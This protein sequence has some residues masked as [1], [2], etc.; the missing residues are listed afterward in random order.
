MN[1]SIW[2][3][4]KYTTPE[5]K[6]GFGGRGFMI[7]KELVNLGYNVT[8]FAS[9]SNHH[10]KAPSFQSLLF[11]EK[12]GSLNFYWVKTSKY[13][14]KQ[15]FLRIIS[16]FSFEINLLISRKKEIPKPDIIIVSSLSLLSVLTGLF[17]KLFYKSILIFEVRDIWPLTLTE[18]GGYSKKSIFIKILGIIES[19]G[20]KYSDHIVGTMPNLIEHVKNVTGSDLDVSC[21]PMGYSKSDFNRSKNLT[22]HQVFHSIPDNAFVIGYVGSLGVSNALGTFFSLLRQHKNNSKLCFIVAGDGDLS[23]EFKNEFNNYDNVHY[24]GTIPRVEVF[25]VLSNCDLLYLSTHDSEVWKYGQ[26]L[27]KLVDYMLSGVPIVA[28]YSGYKSMI[29]ESNCGV[30]ISP[31]NTSAL[32]KC[33]SSFINMDQSARVQMGLNGRKWIENNRSYDKLAKKYNLIFKNLTDK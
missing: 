14:K 11:L 19:I 15:S 3:I 27:N 24:L 9:D 12:F 6:E 29:D 18:E 17:Y 32:N 1:N 8:I 30:F 22:K 20:Y 16:W 28:S 33:F 31:N 25:S 7:C 23:Q 21:I 13:R 10:A 2:Y 5:S 4:S 26:S